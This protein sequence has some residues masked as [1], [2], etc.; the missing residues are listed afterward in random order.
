MTATSPNHRHT[1]LVRAFW[2][3]A[4]SGSPKARLSWRWLVAGKTK[5]MVAQL[6]IDATCNQSMAAIIPTIE[7]KRDTC[8]GGLRRT[9]PTSATWLAVR[10]RDGLNLDLLGN[11][12]CP[13]PSDEEQRAIADFLDRETAKLDTLMVKKRT[14]IERLTEKRIALISS[15][16]SHVASRPG[17][18]RAA[19]CA[20]TGNMGNRLDRIHG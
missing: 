19:G 1:S 20:T 14:L 7:F 6:G 16:G 18:A 8:I 5:A 2:E 15:T 4:R 9:T 12:P 3:A 17:A 13:V 10:Q 11:I